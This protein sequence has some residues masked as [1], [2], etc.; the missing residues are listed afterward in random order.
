MRPRA[1]G[2][3]PR[4][5]STARSPLGVVGS[6]K[7][8][9]PKDS[10]LGPARAAISSTLGRAF[11]LFATHPIGENS[12]RS[13]ESAQ[14]LTRADAVKT[15]TDVWMDSTGLQ[16]FWVSRQCSVM[17]REGPEKKHPFGLTVKR[18]EKPRDAP[19]WACT[20]PERN[21]VQSFS[22][23]MAKLPATLIV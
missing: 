4:L 6:G 16:F 15:K 7:K 13:G 21:S 12:M 18:V 8:A 20:W 14:S 3:Q 11:A 10:A 19:R 2:P 9:I 22:P 17:K 5:G 23:L 1:L